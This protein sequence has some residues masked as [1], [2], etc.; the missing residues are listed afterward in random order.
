VR[1]RERIADRPYD[2]KRPAAIATGAQQGFAPRVIAAPRDERQQRQ[3]R[4]PRGSWL[5]H[6]PPSGRDAGDGDA[7]GAGLVH[8]EDGEAR[9]E[10]VLRG[11]F[12]QPMSTRAGS[13][14]T[15]QRG[16]SHPDTAGERSR[17]AT[18]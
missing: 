9:G 15:T 2:E 10:Q 8:G 17:R 14:S 11:R 6:A 16:R 7:P 12:G 5:S 1:E 13:D 3:T 4:A 18:R